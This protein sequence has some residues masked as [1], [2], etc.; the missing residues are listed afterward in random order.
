MMQN[1]LTP[2]YVDNIPETL[3]EGVL[4][5]CKRYTLA[6]HK[7]CCG[8][9]EEVITP[10]TPADWS[11]RKEEGAVTL[12]PSIGNWSFA[13]RSH[14]WIRRNQ[15]VWSRTMSPREIRQVRDRDRREKAAYIAGV[16]TRK[17]QRAIPESPGATHEETSRSAFRERWRTVVLWWKSWANRI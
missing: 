14:Y 4:Y 5:I 9:G 13:C 16:N 3:A 2:K 11:L 10:L 1:T 8:C 7:C 6:A 12:N 17:A 15:V